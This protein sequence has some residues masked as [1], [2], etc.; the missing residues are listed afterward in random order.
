MAALVRTVFVGVHFQDGMI[1]A[2]SEAG[3]AVAFALVKYSVIYM[4][5]A[6]KCTI[7]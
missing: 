3:Y 4:T 7:L 1:I 2:F 6:V 5:K